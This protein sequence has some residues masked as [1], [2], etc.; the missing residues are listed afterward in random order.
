V[1]LSSCERRADFSKPCGARYTDLTRSLVAVLLPVGLETQRQQ[2]VQLQIV[3]GG[4]GLELSP[5]VGGHAEI[6]RGQTRPAPATNKASLL[7]DR[8]IRHQAN[9][10]ERMSE[11]SRT[12]HRRP[13]ARGPSPEA[14]RAARTA[15][16]STPPRPSDLGYK[17]PGGWK[18]GSASRPPHLHARCSPIF[19]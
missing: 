13:R 3:C 11:A 2:L 4:I 8:M 19:Y 5:K 18:M 14:G 6:E 16:W 9:S 1:G 17:T 12:P 15:G 7:V 10:V